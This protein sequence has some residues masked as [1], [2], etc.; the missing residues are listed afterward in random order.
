MRP[1]Q[2]RIFYISLAGALLVLFVAGL[3]FGYVGRRTSICADHK[4]PVSQN[5]NG[6]G[7]ILFRC[8]NGQIVTNNNG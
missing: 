5:D 8:Q 1:R 7:Q 3:V 4:P 2:K 6:L